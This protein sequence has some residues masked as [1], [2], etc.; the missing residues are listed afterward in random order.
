M[1]PPILSPDLL[2]II[3]T[4]PYKQLIN[5]GN[6]ETASFQY[7]SKFHCDPLRQ[8]GKKSPKTKPSRLWRLEYDENF[9]K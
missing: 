2:H 1:K 7:Y 4:R 5:H 9:M 3:Q 6:L 8:L